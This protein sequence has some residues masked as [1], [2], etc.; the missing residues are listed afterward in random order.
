MSAAKSL[1]ICFPLLWPSGL[2]FYIQTS[3]GS[4]ADG[5]TNDEQRLALAPQRSIVLKTPPGP[6]SLIRYNVRQKGRQTQIG[7]GDEAS[8]EKRG[9][10][11]YDSST[12]FKPNLGPMKFFSDAQDATAQL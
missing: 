10:A 11:A 4:R 9:Y 6:G 8:W 5:D 7:N 3:W 12:S 1:I 2:T